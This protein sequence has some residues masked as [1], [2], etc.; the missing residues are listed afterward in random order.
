MTHD[1][2]ENTLPTSTTHGADNRL[3][4]EGRVT[5]KAVASASLN[6]FKDF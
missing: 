5:A 2:L 3:S 4:P 1:F 6:I